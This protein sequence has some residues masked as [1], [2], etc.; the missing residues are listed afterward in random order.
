MKFSQRFSEPTRLSPRDF[1]GLLELLTS[2]DEAV[3]GVQAYTAAQ[4][5]YEALIVSERAYRAEL[6]TYERQINVS[7]TELVNKKEELSDAFLKLEASKDALKSAWA[8]FNQAKEELVRQTAQFN[9]DVEKQKAALATETKE[10]RKDVEQKAASLEEN[11]VAFKKW[12]AELGEREVKA[13]KREADADEF[14][15]LLGKVR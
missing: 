9:V 15:K 10:R 12:E 1:Y 2:P 3:K 5:E 4:L 14:K 11:I 13:A 7:Q 8:T 6:E